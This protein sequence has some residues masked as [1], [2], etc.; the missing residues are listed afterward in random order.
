M[1]NF[2]FYCGALKTAYF[3]QY[4]KQITHYNALLFFKKKLSIELTSPIFVL[5]LMCIPI[6]CGCWSF[7]IHI[8]P[9]QIEIRCV[10]TSDQHSWEFQF[11]L[12]DLKYLLI[13]STGR[14]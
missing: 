9:F 3:A 11:Q 8:I 6:K 14:G 5:N 7:F 13:N 1:L 4:T 12:A 10:Y 2:H